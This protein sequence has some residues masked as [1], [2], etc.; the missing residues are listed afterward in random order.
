MN[1]KKNSIYLLS[2]LSQKE[3]KSLRNAYE[4]EIKLLRDEVE[5]EN[6]SLRNAYEKKIKSLRDKREKKITSLNDEHHEKKIKSLNEAYD[7]EIQYLNDSY[8]QEIKFSNKSYEQQIKS[9]DKYNQ[10][11]GNLFHW[12][13][14]AII[15]ISAII[16]SLYL[17]TIFA[18]NNS[19]LV[20][21]YIFA[22]ICFFSITLLSFVVALDKKISFSL[23]LKAKIIYF[24]S[25]FHLRH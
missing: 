20:M 25:Y 15:V 21:F 4:R 23:Y 22:F 1:T 2:K 16:S 19:P 3:N 17:V 12:D 18:T 10:W 13:L 5:K 24:F 9:K 11:I 8:E 14:Q 6:K 7:Q